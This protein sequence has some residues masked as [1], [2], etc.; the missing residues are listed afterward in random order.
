MNLINPQ[1]A[2]INAYAYLTGA[3][4]PVVT[5]SKNVSSV[6]DNGTGAYTLNFAS[7]LPSIN[8]CVLANAESDTGVET[9]GFVVTEY[10]NARATTSVRV[11]VSYAT[12]SVYDVPS[13]SVAI[14]G[15]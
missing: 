1:N 3:G 12:N 5:K 10:Y 7:T 2:E 9:Y 14:L 13:V 15:A 6:T 11:Q 4:T 8:Y